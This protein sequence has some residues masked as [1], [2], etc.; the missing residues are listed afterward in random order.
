[1]ESEPWRPRSASRLQTDAAA[2]LGAL[3]A[4]RDSIRG[5]F[6]AAVAKAQRAAADAH[7]AGETARSAVARG[8]DGEAGHCAAAARSLESQGRALLA[9]ARA[10]RRVLDELGEQ[11]S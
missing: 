5:R 8:S 10:A 1:M 2:R 4:W 6:L 11:A 3:Q 9:A 7:L